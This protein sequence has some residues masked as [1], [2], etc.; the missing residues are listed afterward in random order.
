MI[1][2]PRPPKVLG[3]QA[4][5]G[6]RVG[7]LPE[8]RS[9]RPAWPM[10][11]NPV[12]IKNTK[13]SQP[14]WRKSIISATWESEAGGVFEPRR[15]RLQTQHIRAS[16]GLLRLLSQKPRAAPL[17]FPAPIPGSA[18]LFFYDY[19]HKR[20][21]K[22]NPRPD[23]VADAYNLSTLGGQG[24]RIGRSLALLPRLEGSGTTLAH[25]NLCL[26]GSSNSPSAS[27]VAGIVGT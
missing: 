3:L 27:Q 15:Q 18:S 26:L 23:M 16:E 8:V 2:L 25:C 11:R 10:W 7:R 6:G 14:W 5:L 24:R 22:G 1:C 19:S 4:T 12:S 13:I 9:L 17:P 21:H 20:V